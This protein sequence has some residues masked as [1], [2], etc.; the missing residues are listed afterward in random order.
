MLD[1]T[2]ASKEDLDGVGDSTTFS[3][4]KCWVQ[5]NHHGTR[6]RVSESRK[7]NFPVLVAHA[8]N[9]STLGRQRQEDFCGQPVKDR[10]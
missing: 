2:T 10:T 6:R 7:P 5:K 1:W 4:N 3:R 9:P 8:F